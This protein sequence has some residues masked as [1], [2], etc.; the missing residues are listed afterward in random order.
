VDLS[1]VRLAFLALTACG[2]AHVVAPPPPA[3]EG[4]AEVLKLRGVTAV[5]AIDRADVQVSGDFGPFAEVAVVITPSD[6]EDRTCSIALRL[7]D[8]WYLT[9]A[10]EDVCIEPGYIEL[11]SASSERE[12]DGVISVELGIQWHTNDYDAEASYALA[13]ICG[14][15]DDQLSCLPTFVSNCELEAPAGDCDER[16]HEWIYRVGDDGTVTIDRQPPRALFR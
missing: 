10:S 6:V 15:R 12:A 1:A 9:A 8:H 3:N 11:E 5:R 16:A 14:V 7:G 2:G 13:T 4:G